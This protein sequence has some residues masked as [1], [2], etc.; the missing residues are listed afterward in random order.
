LAGQDPEAARRARAS[1]AGRRH[2]RPAHDVRL[3]LLRP[4]HHRR[5]DGG[6]LPAGLQGGAREPRPG[7]GALGVR[8]RSAWGRRC[9][10]PAL[11]RAESC[12]MGGARLDWR[13]IAVMQMKEPPSLTLSELQARL[14]AFTHEYL[15]GKSQETV[16]TYRRTLN[17][18]ERW[19]ATQRGRF[20]FRTEDVEAYKRYLMEE[21]R[22]SQVSV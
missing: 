14:D 9:A 20:R 10:P 13:C 11:F 5:R 3:A 16:G 7:R 4:P 6:Q 17:E 1:P 8:G 2:R 21:R 12:G 15:R 18:F 22:L 19:F